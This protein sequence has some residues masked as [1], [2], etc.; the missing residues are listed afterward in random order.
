MFLRY[1]IYSL[2]LSEQESNRRR[3]TEERHA[4]V[5]VCEFDIEAADRIEV[6]A[7]PVLSRFPKFEANT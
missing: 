2:S 5:D 7:V 4:A 1:F 6:L 3:D